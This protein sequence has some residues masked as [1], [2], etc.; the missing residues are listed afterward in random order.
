MPVQQGAAGKLA[1]LLLTRL[2]QPARMTPL[3]PDKPTIKAPPCLI[4]C[5][6]CPVLCSDEELAQRARQWSIRD[7]DLIGEVSC[8]EP[9]EWQDPTGAEWEFSADLGGSNGTQ[10]FHVRLAFLTAWPEAL[11]GQLLEVRMAGFCTHHRAFCGSRRALAQQPTTDSAVVTEQ[12]C[13][14]PA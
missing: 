14:A 3:Q 5:Q 8:T 13:F 4:P 6:Q 11:A 7:L 9:Y 12:W 2:C 10:P 1:V